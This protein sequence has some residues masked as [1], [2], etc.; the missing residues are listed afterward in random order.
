M[1]PGGWSPDAIPREQLR[2]VEVVAEGLA[3]PEGPVALSDGSVLVTEIDRGRLVRVTPRG[4]TELVAECGGGP[5]GAA[6]GPD[7]AVYVCNNGGRFASGN[8]NGGWIERVDLATGDVDIVYRQCESRRLS[9]P[10]DLVFDTTGNFWFTDT[11]KFRG[12][13]RDVGSVYYAHADGSRIVEVVHPAE[14]PNG[15][16][17]SPDLS[18]LYYAETITGRLRRRHLDGPGRLAEEEPNDPAN[19]VVGLPGHQGFDSLA[20][21]SE[22]NVCIATLVT[23]CVTVVAPD[24]TAVVQRELPAGMEDAMV[25][26]IC[27]GGEDLRTTFVTLA[28][29]GRLIRCRWPVPGMPLVYSA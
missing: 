7:G 19:L 25:T 24:G 23:G 15:I 6:I 22:G 27:F 4:K 13:E 16:G 10:N 26:N 3:F 17:L 21:D 1:S 20:V 11:G 29:T 9:G 8:W 18:T 12:R 28:A 14:A 2:D 5:N